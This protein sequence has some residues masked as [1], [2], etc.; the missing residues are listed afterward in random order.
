VQVLVAGNELYGAK[1]TGDN[2]YI[3]VKLGKNWGWY[4]GNDWT[5]E[6]SGERY[7]V[8]SKKK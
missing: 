5:L 4:P 8:W 7:A 1:I 6:T 3:V 2:Y